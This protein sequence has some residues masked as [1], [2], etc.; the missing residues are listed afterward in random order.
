LSSSSETTHNHRTYGCLLTWTYRMLAHEPLTQIQ[1]TLFVDV[2]SSSGNLT[3]AGCAT[4]S[5]ELVLR[6]T[7]RPVDGSS[8]TVFVAACL[9]GSFAKCDISCSSICA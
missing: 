9:S 1:G 6:L 5:G 2:G 4:L 3:V 8:R 7:E